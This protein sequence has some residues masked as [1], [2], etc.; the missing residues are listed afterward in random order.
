MKRHRSDHGFHI[1][2]LCRLSR[3]KTEAT[4]LFA[5]FSNSMGERR[6]SQVPQFGLAMH[7]GWNKSLRLHVPP[8]LSASWRG[9]PMRSLFVAG[10]IFAAL[11]GGI[12]CAPAQSQTPA[13]PLTAVP[14]ATECQRGLTAPAA[15]GE[16][17]GSADLS[18]KLSR[19]KGVICPPTGI[20]P[21]ISAPPVGGGVTP[22]IPP[23]GTRGGDPSI[24][25]K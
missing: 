4:I 2:W 19:S 21:G 10:G 23:P 24:I 15:S 1:H 17:T 9:T 11:A 7:A 25:P 6:P 5:K 8:I 18:D 22:V 16:T 20:D 13:P 14:P 12:P 3:P